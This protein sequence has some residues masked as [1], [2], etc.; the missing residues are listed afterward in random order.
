MSVPHEAATPMLRTTP[1]KSGRWLSVLLAA[2]G[3]GLAIVAAA[4]FSN[5]PPTPVPP[6]AGM[7]IGQHDI[8]L[9]PKAPQWSVLRLGQA[10]APRDT[11]TDPIPARVRIDETNAARVGSPLPGRV[12]KV[13]VELGQHVK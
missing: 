1:S 2:L 3:G 11:Y 5:K 6:P 7:Q 9:S 4:M 13:L 8:S 10:T 12:N